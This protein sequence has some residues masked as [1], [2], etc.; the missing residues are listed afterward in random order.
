METYPQ[1]RAVKL[2]GTDKH[3]Y[4]P[5]AYNTEWGCCAHSICPAKAVAQKDNLLSL[6]ESAYKHT[7]CSLDTKSVHGGGSCYLEPTPGVRTQAKSDFC[8]CST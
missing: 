8:H 2:R 3:S 5:L 6:K 1:E 4:C 7:G